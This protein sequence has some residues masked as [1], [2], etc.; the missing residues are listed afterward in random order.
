[1]TPR[2]LIDRRLVDSI[3]PA[4]RDIAKAITAEVRAAVGQVL[5]G[6][7][8]PNVDPLDVVDAVAPWAADLARGL[9]WHGLMGRGGYARD[10]ILQLATDTLSASSLDE[11]ARDLDVTWALQHSR[12][13]EQIAGADGCQIPSVELHERY[14]W[15]EVAVL[16]ARIDLTFE[17][18]RLMHRDS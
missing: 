3:G 13:V 7:L 8:A 9:H 18:L 12:F 4:P 17:M 11:L 16:G 5:G 15:L 1:M 10:L 2:P 6:V 14:P